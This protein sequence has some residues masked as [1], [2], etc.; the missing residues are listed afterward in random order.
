MILGIHDGTHDAGAALVSRGRIVAACNEERFTRR[1]GSGA[2]PARSVRACL[3]VAGITIDD[4]EHVAFPGLVN[5]NPGL[6]ALRSL[7]KKWLLD[8]DRFYTESQGFGALFSQWLQFD[9]FFPRLR[10]GSPMVQAYRPALKAL[11]AYQLS[12]DLRGNSGTTVPHPGMAHWLLRR[13]R[14]AIHDHH[15]C[16]A[17][18][19][20][21]C[22]GQDQVL[23]LVADGL[24]DGLALSVWEGMGGTLKMLDGMP[25]PHS[26]GLLASTITG[27]L[28]FRPFR[29]EGKVM[30]L[31]AHGD[32]GAVGVAFPFAGPPHRRTFTR[33]FGAPM[34]PWLDEL[35]QYRR[36]DI[37]AW[38]Q[39][40]L[41]DDIS[42]LVQYWSRR[43]GL[44]GLAVAGGVFA[45]VQLNRRV[46]DLSEV[47]SLHVFPHMGDGGLGA[48][49]ALASDMAL[50]PEHWAPVPL[51]DVFLG[52]AF[53]ESEA[54]TALRDSGLRWSRPTRI[55]ES[56]ARLL[57]RGLIV[58][59]VAGRMEF[60]PRALGHRSILFRADDEALVRRLNS[61]LWRSEF[62][63]FAPA[64]RAEAAPELMGN[65]GSV[66][67][68]AQ[69][70]TV[71]VQAGSRLEGMCPA[72]VHVDGSIRPQL[73]E[74]S[75][76]PGFHRILL[77]YQ[78]ETGQPM[79]INTSFN[80]HE[81]PI[82]Q[83]PADAVRT[84]KVAQ[85]DAMAL[86]PFLV[87]P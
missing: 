82:V 67:H 60:G 70:M 65:L 53:S 56:V 10:A 13:G 22:A 81:E 69:Y 43:T 61:Q 75:V 2:W 29:H 77:E 41:E 40:G 52:P 44:G 8:C 74:K 23:V 84:F 21:H 63:P 47:Q 4:V 36:D 15:L 12:A 17:A 66:A 33:S 55:E 1:K 9:S 49:A 3:D 78:R 79:L 34:R 46:A 30:A 51:H 5:P 18:G 64:I 58:A 31:A 50:H 71:A 57:A 38:L 86:G 20:Y 37:C 87:R 83:S 39:K 11:L 54:E 80:V 76:S 73:V 24:G 14:L 62:M 7:Q 85:L 42:A 35:R 32:P 28:G 72:V 45:N 25:F 59:R 16:H 19:A 6:R 68:A 27:L 48:G 26:Y